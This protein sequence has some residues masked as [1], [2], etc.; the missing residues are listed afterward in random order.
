MCS[1]PYRVTIRRCLVMEG[2][3]LATSI[4]EVSLERG[5]ERDSRQD[6][7]VGVSKEHLL[8]TGQGH[9]WELWLYCTGTS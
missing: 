3:Q 9:A 8:L 7:G 5:E 2:W 1:W 6:V 4:L